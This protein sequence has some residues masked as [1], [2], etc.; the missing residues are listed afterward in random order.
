M[1][2]YLY[3]PGASYTLIG[4]GACKDATGKVPWNYAKAGG[5]SKPVCQ[6]LCTDLGSP[7]VGFHTSTS[8]YCVVFGSQLQGGEEWR[9]RGGFAF[10]PG[11]GGTDT[12]TQALGSNRF[13]CHVKNAKATAT[14]SAAIPTTAVA[15][16]PTTGYGTLLWIMRP[17]LLTVH[18]LNKVA[19][20][21]RLPL[22]K[23][24]STITSA[25]HPM[26]YG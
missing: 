21:V 26:W 20:A 24:Q 13:E 4:K 23:S 1:R 10:S 15:A 11:N 7:C 14:S 22:L 18:G 6:D 16:P 8:G 17:I 19:W 3:A 12:L 9:D 5:V 25:M 2:L